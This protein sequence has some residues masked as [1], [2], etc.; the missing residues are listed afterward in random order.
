MHYA[1]D[2]CCYLNQ[3]LKSTKMD[4]NNKNKN[5]QILINHFKEQSTSTFFA[6]CKVADK[7]M[8][9]A[10]KKMYNID[11]IEQREQKL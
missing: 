6:Q 8:K 2:P 10:K 11:E 7:S 9:R 5:L 3:K 1:F 4:E